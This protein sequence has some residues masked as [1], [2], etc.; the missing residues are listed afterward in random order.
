M[1]MKSLEKPG[2]LA[3]A[4]ILPFPLEKTRCKEVALPPS[5]N[6]SL[7]AHD[8]KFAR[9]DIRS[10]AVVGRSPAD[11]TF[12]L[13]PFVVKMRRLSALGERLRSVEKMSREMAYYLQ[14]IENY[15]PRKK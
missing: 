13:P 1:T 5:L 12:L 4:C 9:L 15:S 14:E 6:E 10:A 2:S 11:I 7:Q 3:K 8:E